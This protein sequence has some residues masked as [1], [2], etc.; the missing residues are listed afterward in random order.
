M[1]RQYSEH[2]DEVLTDVAG[3]PADELAKMREDGVIV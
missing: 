2:T 1:F 3:V